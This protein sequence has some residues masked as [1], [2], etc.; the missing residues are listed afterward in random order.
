MCNGLTTWI[1]LTIPRHV[2]TINHNL[3]SSSIMKKKHEIMK[4][5]Q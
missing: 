4:V 2:F 5:L 1:E 3:L